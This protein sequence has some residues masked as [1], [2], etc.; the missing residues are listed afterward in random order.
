MSVVNAN[1]Y[2]VLV[3]SVA[4]ISCNSVEMPSFIYICI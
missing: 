3:V 1:E 4:L 2:S